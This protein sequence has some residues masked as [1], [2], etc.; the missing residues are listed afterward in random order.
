MV[1]ATFL[2]LFCVCV[3]VCVASVFLC[4]MVFFFFFGTLAKEGRGGLGFVSLKRTLAKA[5]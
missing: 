4:V 3:A 5:R 2:L 1:E